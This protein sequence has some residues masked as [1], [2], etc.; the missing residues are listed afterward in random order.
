MPLSN[1]SFNFIRY[2]FYFLTFLK[3]LYHLLV[4]F[5]KKIGT[6]EQIFVFKT[7]EQFLTRLLFN[8][9]AQILVR[10]FFEDSLVED[11]SG[12]KLSFVVF[13]SKRTSSAKDEQ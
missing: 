5:I 12:V 8:C 4:L 7:I 1:P 6:V 10:I 11:K 9:P 13:L 3:V 2:F